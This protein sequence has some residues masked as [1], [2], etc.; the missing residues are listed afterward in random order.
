MTESEQVGEF[1]GMKPLDVYLRYDVSVEEVVEFAL[2]TV[3]GRAGRISGMKKE[4]R[5]ALE[6]LFWPRWSLVSG[7]IVLSDFAS[8]NLDAWVEEFGGDVRRAEEMVNH[9]HL[10]DWFEGDD[11]ELA[12]L[13]GTAAIIAQC[14]ESKLRDDFPGRSQRVR[15]SVGSYGPEVTMS[16]A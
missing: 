13:E 11:S 6:S 10:W 7:S 2:A 16:R 5:E 12:R 9:I 8:R 1:S 3:D 14:W 4:T 15:W